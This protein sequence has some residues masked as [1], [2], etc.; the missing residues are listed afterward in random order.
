MTPEGKVKKKVR[1]FLK[2]QGVYFFFPQSGGYGRSGVPDI[3]CCAYGRFLAIECKA[4][5]DSK[6]TELQEAQLR[7][8][9]RHQGLTYV[10]NASNADMVL[11]ALEAIFSIWKRDG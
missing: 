3:I 7:E 11:T 8:I 6:L 9:Q 2:K 4:Q 10:I 1:E 5:A